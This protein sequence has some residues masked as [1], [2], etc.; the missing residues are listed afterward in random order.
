MNW[1]VWPVATKNLAGL[2][3]AE[4]MSVVSGCKR[5]ARKGAEQ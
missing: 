5:L 1:R 2:K 4:G 3:V